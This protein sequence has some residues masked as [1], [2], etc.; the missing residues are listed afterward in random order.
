MRLKLSI[1]NIAWPK[2][3]DEEMYGHLRTMGYSGLEIA[4]SR[5]FGDK[6]YTRIAE[7]AQW[8]RD[9]KRTYGLNVPSMQSIWYGRTENMFK[10]RGETESL[11]AYSQA[12]VEFAGAVGCKNLVFGCPRNRNMEIP[13]EMCRK[14]AERFFSRLGAMAE[15][16]QAR[17]GIEANPEIYHTNYLNTTLEAAK[18]LSRLAVPGLGLN[19]DTGTMLYNKETLESIRPW[20][21]WITHVHISEPG[22]AKIERRAFHVSLL[23]ELVQ[24]GYTGYVSVEMGAC[25]TIQEVLEVMSY[26]KEVAADAES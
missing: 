20:S 10:S 25:G 26:V 21:N 19:L 1:S 12:A 6:P 16:Q 17:F 9:L 11:L 8:A 2:E 14:E 5:L 3:A 15:K 23:R 22:L 7:A 13:S 24:S 4:P 18:L